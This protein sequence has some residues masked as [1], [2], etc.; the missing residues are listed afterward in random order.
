M[1]CRTIAVANQKGGVG[2]T[3]TTVNLAYPSALACKV[4]D[5]I[6]K[7][8][9]DYGEPVAEYVSFSKR[10]LDELVGRA[11]WGGRNGNRLRVRR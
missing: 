6:L 10:E 4:C 8:F 5:A 9:S 3:T 11:S 1:A 7:K 2:K